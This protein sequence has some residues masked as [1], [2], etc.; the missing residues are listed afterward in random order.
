MRHDETGTQDGS[1]RN[2]K[3]R[4]KEEGGEEGMRGH[5]AFAIFSC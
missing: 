4:K 5:E 3:K 1:Q 2:I